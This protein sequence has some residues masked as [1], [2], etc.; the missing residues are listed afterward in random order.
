MSS[1]LPITLLSLEQ[2]VESENRLIVVDCYAEWC[3]PCK[4]IAPEISLLSDKYKNNNN[5]ILVLM[6][7]VDECDDIAAK[8]EIK[9]LPTILYFKHGKLIDRFIGAN[10]IEIEKKIVTYWQ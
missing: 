4:K 8:Y 2:L 3:G 5:G 7:D 9:S 10:M 6:L 1:K